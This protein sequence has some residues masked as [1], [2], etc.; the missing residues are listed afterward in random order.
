M[1][2]FGDKPFGLRQVKLVNA[3]GTVTVDLPAAMTFSFG[4]KMISDTLR[5]NDRT[6]AAASFADQAEWELENGGISLEAYALMTGRAVVAGGS[7]ANETTTLTLRA[8]D[9]FPYF[10]VYGKALGPNGDDIHVKLTHCK[11]MGDGLNG[12]FQDGKF[13]ITK[14]KGVALG[15]EANNYQFA[16]I[17]QNETAGNLPT[18]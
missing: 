5:G 11:L 1:A 10:K 3:A 9:A 14:C 8:G 12:Q 15:D 16:E 7:G 6:L 4:E 13:L 17:V 18:T 2:G